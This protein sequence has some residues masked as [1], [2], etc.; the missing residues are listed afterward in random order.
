VG[1]TSNAEIKVI[2]AFEKTPQQIDAPGR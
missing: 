2:E 1:A